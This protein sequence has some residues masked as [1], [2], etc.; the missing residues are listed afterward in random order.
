MELTVR[1]LK[2]K[3]LGGVLLKKVERY[4]IIYHKV[5]WDY[6]NN[7]L[8]TST[9][10]LGAFWEEER[11]DIFDLLTP[12]VKY[13]IAQTTSI[14]QVLDIS[15]VVGHFKS[16]FGYESIP[17]NT[18]TL[19]LNRLSPKILTRRNGQYIL[20]VSLDREIQQFE[21][22]HATF[23][24]HKGKVADAL[25]EHLNT[26]LPG[27]KKFNKETALDALIKFFATNGMCVISDVALL[28]MIKNKDDQLKYSI[29]QFVVN[30]AE[31]NTAVFTY[32][33]D[34]VKGFFVSNAI[35][36]QPQNTV[37]TESKFKGLDCYIDTRVIINAL[38]MHTPAER[39][40]SAE[41]LVMLKEKG[42][43]LLCFEHNFDEIDSIV[44]AYK[45]GLKY[46]HSSY[47]H[48][49]LEGWDEQHYTVTDVERYQSVLRHK[50]EA[51]G[52]TIVQK[53]DVTKAAKEY[54]F[55]DT[56][57]ESHICANMTYN[58]KDALSVDIASIASILLL[59]SGIK[60]KEI[61]K[62]G[63]IFVTSNIQLTNLSNGFL[64][65]QGICGSDNEVLPIITDVDLSSIVWLKCYSTH[66][67]YPKRKLIEH[68]LVA[69]ELT[70][71][72]VKTF[73]Q[74]VDRIKA[75]GEITEDEAA[76]IRTEYFCKREIAK[77]VKGDLSKINEDSVR[78]VRRKLREQYVGE[79][80]ATAA[81]NWNK[82]QEEKQKRREAMLNA[83]EEIKRVG[84]KAYDQTYNNSLIVIWCCIAA[85]WIAFIVLSIISF[86]DSTCL[87]VAISLFIFGLLG[88]V[89]M[90]MSKLNLLKKYAAK[91]A[92]QK[93][94]GHMDAKRD[95]YERILG[96][97]LPDELE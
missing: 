55:S 35:S 39:E 19:I 47:Y 15:K 63:S 60:A 23:E 2:M 31:Q 69:L 93:A 77:S 44:T 89:D 50:I 88:T 61:E 85:F 52:I 21:K 11:K 3:H 48:P 51:L 26:H 29:A 5:R 53:P 9:A 68:S 6:M 59:R 38:G 18:V 7:S 78:D 25:V 36:L 86:M 82:Y 24:E 40:A 58:N 22:G 66:K 32:I 62:C 33:V 56:E 96:F 71:T 64:L 14:K 72:M 17:T 4:D 34:M 81:T 12:F 91:C 76:V 20:R 46:A 28:H 42:A 41:M 13:S 87:W 70:P 79:A 67:D 49:T 57:I 94:A 27:Y 92:N 83:V 65:Q 10:M 1:E 43:T 30:E 37:V 74:M 90:T 75:E 80:D 97:N 45:N 8:L 73:N 16:Y 95:E 54:P 84:K